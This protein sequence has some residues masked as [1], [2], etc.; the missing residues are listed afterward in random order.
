MNQGCGGNWLGLLLIQPGTHDVDDLLAELLEVV[1]DCGGCQ[2][3][4]GWARLQL[5]QQLVDG[6]QLGCAVILAGLQL[7]D[8]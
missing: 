7:L 4:V 6:V 2:L 5:L 8:L 3:D 1:V